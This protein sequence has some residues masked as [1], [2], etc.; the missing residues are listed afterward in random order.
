MSFLY[1]LLKQLFLALWLCPPL[2][3]LGAW[4]RAFIF[5]ETERSDI[6]NV[7]NVAR[8]KVGVSIEVPTQFHG[9]GQKGKDP[10]LYENCKP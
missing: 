2:S 4:K 3:F 10:Q 7:L 9:L 8:L 5:N 6:F 1:N